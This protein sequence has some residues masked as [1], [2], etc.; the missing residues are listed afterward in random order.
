MKRNSAT[1]FLFL[2][3]TAGVFRC[4]APMLTT[5]NSSSET[6]NGFVVGSL[7]KTDGSAAEYTI[8][9]LLPDKYDPVKDGPVPDSLI[10]TTDARGTFQFRVSGEGMFNIEGVRP[11]T[12][13]RVLITGVEVGKTDTVT[14]TR[15][16]VQNPGSIKIV[17]Q[18][19]VNTV[20]GYL[21][22]PGTFIFAYL[23]NSQGTVVLDSVPADVNVDVAFS[24]T[25][26]PQASLLRGA[27]RVPSRDTAIVWNPGWLHARTMVLNTAASGAGVTGTVT[28]FPVLV[29]LTAGNFDFTQARNNGED[30]R[31]AKRDNTFLPYEI[32]LW[33]PVAERAEIW[34]KVDTVY[35]NDSAQSI[36]MYWGDIDAPAQSNPASV[37]DTGSGFQGVWHLGENGDG[38]FDA[39]GDAFNGKNTGSTP[40]AGMIGNARNFASGNYIKIPGLLNSPANVT[41]S[42][43]VLSD[44]SNWGKNNNWGQ[45]IVS[46]GDYALI[47]LDDTYGIGTSGWYQNKPIG[48]GPD[49]SFISANSGRYLANTGWHFLAFSINSATHEQA[50]YIDGVQCAVANDV[51][52]ICYSGLGVDTYIGIHGNGEKIYNFSG[53][54]DEV[55][56]SKISLSQDW[57]KLC[58]MNQ[59]KQDA[60]VKW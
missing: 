25:N 51:N 24:A 58:Y 3:V 30:I 50:L 39:T 14:V 16:A 49:S 55:R 48:P 32:E 17:L 60:L 10:D 43:W 11:K 29:R 18:A 31:F 42:A 5:G 36:S 46:I 54:I 56:V 59:K 52:P 53:R 44:T 57:I 23:K 8:V 2:A 37:F 21:Y 27:I 41:L 7:V 15:H 28:G 12:G 19:G 26:S 45:D 1:V 33:D 47:R 4:S 34:V 35:G 22:I 38:V 9:K 13:E 6:T 20:N 40:A